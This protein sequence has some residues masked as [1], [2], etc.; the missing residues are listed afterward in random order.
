MRA[1]VGAVCCIAE[2][3]PQK[4][5][6]FRRL[7]DSEAESYAYLTGLLAN[8]ARS[9]RGEGGMSGFWKETETRGFCSCAMQTRGE[10]ICTAVL[11]RR[12]HSRDVFSSLP[13]PSIL[14]SCS[15]VL[16]TGLLELDGFHWLVEE[17]PSICPQGHIET[18]PAGLTLQLF[19]LR[20]ESRLQGTHMRTGR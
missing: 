8:M 20:D 12:V 13:G 9:P 17:R 1:S 2:C 15:P 6:F 5:T 11:F 16:L 3:L 19:V 10:H 4:K 18:T 14:P 7:G